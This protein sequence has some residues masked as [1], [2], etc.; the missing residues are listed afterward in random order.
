M[1]LASV[2]GTPGPLLD[3]ESVVAYARMRGLLPTEG[4][5]Q[6]SALSG[7]VSNVVLKVQA[8]DREF[9]LK[10]A[11]E[12]L[13]VADDWFA[14]PQRSQLEALALQTLSSITPDRVPHV[15][16]AD[17]LRCTLTIDCAPSSWVTWKSELLA[18]RVTPVVAE[19]IG[20]TLGEWHRATAGTGA[21]G[22]FDRHDLLRQLRLEPYFTVSAQRRPQVAGELSSVVEILDASRDCLVHGDFSPKNILVDPQSTGGWVIDHEVA[23]LGHPSFDVAFMAAHLTLKAVHVPQARSQLQQAR[24]AFLNAYGDAPG[25]DPVVLRPLIGAL[26]LARVAGSSPVEYLTPAEQ[27]EVERMA[28]HLLTQPPVDDWLDV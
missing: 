24:T 18:G 26:L 15:I 13:A 17:P 21:L 23:H 25:A 11:L 7:G 2:N 4:L 1:E 22:P 10:Q 27:V 6:V 19:W 12:R 9:V 8:H 3:A 20:S 5:V 16:D 14:D 28:M